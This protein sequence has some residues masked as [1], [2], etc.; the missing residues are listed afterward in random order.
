MKRPLVLTIAILALGAV[1]AF[2]Q[3]KKLTEMCDDRRK[4]EAEASSLGLSTDPSV[5]PAEARHT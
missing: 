1:P 2:F 5:F 4:L 3:Q